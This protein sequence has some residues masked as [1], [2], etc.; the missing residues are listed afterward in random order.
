MKQNKNFVYYY[1]LVEVTSVDSGVDGVDEGM[2]AE[3]WDSEVLQ[4]EDVV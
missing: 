4:T 3:G 1:M 2:K